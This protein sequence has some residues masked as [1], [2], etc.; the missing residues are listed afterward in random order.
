V[1]QLTFM[2]P[3]RLEW[4]DAPEP[5]LEGERE[6]IVRPVAVATCD[7][8]T[9]IVRGR[10][11]FKGPFP[12]GH[13]CIAEVLD[14]GDGV[15]SFEPG[16]LVSVPFQISCGE[17]KRCQS[18][19][20]GNCTG[21][22]RMSMY[23][24]GAL[25]HGE[26]WG[27][28]LSDAVRVPFADHMLVAAPEGTEPEA[29]ASVSDNVSDGWRTVGPYLEEG[30]GAEVLICAGIGSIDIYAT[31]I[32]LALGASQV[33]YVGGRGE[34]PRRARELG[35]NVIDGSF[36]ERLGPYPITVDA[37]S[38]PAG[39]ACA[40]R[41]TEPEGICT[42]VGIYYE[43]ETGMPLLEMYTK[44][45]TFKTGRVHARPVM[46]KVLELVRDGR[47]DPEVATSRVVR[48]DEAAEALAD[49]DSKLVIS[50]A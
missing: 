11:P 34:N 35:A 47:L 32:A 23:G 24:L 13:E 43:P 28:F 45:I 38:D 42:S 5:T 19:Q 1:K 29:I 4:H 17:C 37:S 14:V 22:P 20:T 41:S 7:L 25:G 6:A 46:P 15:G 8:D 44:G 48:W 39:L 40:L 9:A 33:D 27:G 26:R 49:L 50:R 2:E 18:G 3:G 36:P 10:A 30:Q 12:F 31:A 16:A 21:V